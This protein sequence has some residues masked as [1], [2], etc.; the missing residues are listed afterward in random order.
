MQPETAAEAKAWFK[1]ART[2]YVEQKSIWQ[3][4]LPSL[5]M[6]YFTVNKRSRKQ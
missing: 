5:K 1:K 6:P 4:T 2:I 3:L